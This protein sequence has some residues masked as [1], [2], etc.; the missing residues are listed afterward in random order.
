VGATAPA[1]APGP[2]PWDVAAA[3][4]PT[5]APAP[6][7]TAPAPG[8]APWEV[9]A[10]PEPTAAPA[11]WE[12][13]PAPAPASA[14]A[15]VPEVASS[16]WPAA[17]SAAPAPWETAPAPES[18]SAPWETSSAT[19]ASWA[20]AP[21]PAAAASAV[22][23]SWGQADSG[24]G[25]AASEQASGLE[26]GAPAALG[27]APA[28]V[29]R[30]M[31]IAVTVPKGGAGKT[32]L[33][34]NLGVWLGRQLR[35][36]G[37]SVCVVDAN[38]Q[39]SDLGKHIV[40]FQPNIATLV[41][42]MADIGPDRIGRH[43]LTRNDLGCDFLLGP[44]TPEESNAAWITPALYSRAIDSLR[45]LYDYIILDTP[46]AEPHHDLFNEFV[47]PQSDFLAIAVNPHWATIHNAYEWLNFITR[48]ALSG[49][50]GVDESRI[51]IMLNSA[52]EKVGCTEEEVARE[53]A[54]Y[55][56]LGSIPYSSEWK[57][58]AN[59]NEVYAVRFPDGLNRIA[60]DILHQITGE[61]TLLQ[62]SEGTSPVEGKKRRLFGRR[63]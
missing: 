60:G 5:A 37:K 7:E 57:L 56:F 30:G 51:G 33:S 54:S 24:W 20:A 63:R 8:P 3:P 45:S 19:P 31:V 23:E 10:A 49:G 40:A 53:F 28:R 29:T 38:F 59:R 41:R 9:A 39:Q 15:S 22:P 27:H 13:A 42:S 44:P 62:V 17:A 2:A 43:I 25:A 47:L 21:A 18:S 55:R 52:D 6:W 50:Q 14:P 48:P 11:P 46:V 4:E 26:G 61:Q 1:P 36:E 16:S 35:A 58:A 12:T 32:T 34:L